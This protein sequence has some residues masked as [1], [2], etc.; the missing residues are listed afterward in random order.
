[1]DVSDRQQIYDAVKRAHVLAG[2][3]NKAAKRPCI[4]VMIANAGIVFAKRL[5]DLEDEH[6]ERTMNVNLM[7]H[8]WLAKACIP[9]MK[10]RGVAMRH[11][12]I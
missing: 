7:S 12:V 4:D 6:I 11:D 10:T 5:E 2:R 1:M 8:F 3:L 9:Q